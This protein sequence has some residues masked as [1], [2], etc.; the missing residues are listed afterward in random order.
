[1]LEESLGVLAM[2]FPRDKEAKMMLVSA[3]TSDE[4]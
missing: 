3:P 1:M 2:T 4:L